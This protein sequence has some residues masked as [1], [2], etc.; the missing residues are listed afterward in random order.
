SVFG[1]GFLAGENA[2]ARLSQLSAPSP[3]MFAEYPK[4]V[5]RL[6]AFLSEAAEA[7]RTR[8][9]GPVTYA[10]GLWEQVDWAPFDIVS[11]DADLD[12][13]NAA[14]L[15]EQLVAIRSIGKAAAVT[16]FGCCTYRGAA[17]K[18]AA[19]WMILAGEGENRRLDGDYIRD[20]CEQSRY[21]RELLQV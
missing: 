11:V 16:E 17:D 9:A 15:N 10:S 13:T 8:F 1:R 18:G 21:F 4:T 3:E 7:V 20:E 2:Y 5:A 6:N 12:R 14:M 19:G